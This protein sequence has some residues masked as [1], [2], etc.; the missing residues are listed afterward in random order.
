MPAGIT[1]GVPHPHVDLPVVPT[2]PLDQ[3]EDIDDGADDAYSGLVVEAVKCWQHWP[4]PLKVGSENKENVMDEV[5]EIVHNVPEDQAWAWAGRQICPVN[6]LSL[7][8]TEP[9]R[10]TKLWLGSLNI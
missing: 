8:Q 1:A 10:Q 5:T 6:N 4:S 7:S 9:E 2:V 3:V